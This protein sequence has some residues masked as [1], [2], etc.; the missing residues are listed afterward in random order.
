MPDYFPIFEPKTY[1]DLVKAL[2]QLAKKLP[3]PS[4]GLTS[5][6]IAANIVG[7]VVLPATNNTARWDKTKPDNHYQTLAKN[8]DIYETQ[9]QQSAPE[10]DDEEQWWIDCGLMATLVDKFNA[11]NCDDLASYAL[12]YAMQ[13]FSNTLFCY[14]QHTAFNHS[15]L[16][17]MRK[18]DEAPILADVWVS[19]DGAI[20]FQ[21]A[22]WC[23]LAKKMK[24]RVM[25]VA[26][27]APGPGVIDAWKAHFG[28]TKLK[29]FDETD[30]EYP[31]LAQA[32]AYLHRSARRSAANP[33][34]L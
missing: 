22:L 17:V 6:Q 24:L 25:P 30:A 29:A 18:G 12:N 20:P 14:T 23:E 31:R 3:A 2:Q 9:L 26:V 5:Q 4:D 28:K 1:A 10:F 16:L 11:G 13:T 7:T 33:R 27:K 19:E 15:F 21:D 32:G 34:G 8:L